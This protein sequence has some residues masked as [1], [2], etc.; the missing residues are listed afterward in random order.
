MRVYP[1][2]VNRHSYGGSVP[3]KRR[4]TSEYNRLAHLLEDYLN[5]AIAANPEP[6]QQFLYSSIAREL[7]ID[8]TLVR[9]VLFSVDCG[10]NGLTVAR[11]SDALREFLTGNDAMS[12]VDGDAETP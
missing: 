10:H 2:H 7:S 12:D 3:A 9:R 11:S 6:V 8:V 4:K 1:I 5:R